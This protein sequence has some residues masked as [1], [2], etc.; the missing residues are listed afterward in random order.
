MPFFYLQDQVFSQFEHYRYLN[1]GIIKKE[2]Q[3]NGETIPAVPLTTNPK[4]NL[5]IES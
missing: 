4:T 2:L 3:V 1:S 5:C